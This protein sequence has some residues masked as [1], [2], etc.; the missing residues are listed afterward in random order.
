MSS[1]QL[2]DVSDI[3]PDGNVW[4]VYTST[5]SEKDL[6]FKFRGGTLQPIKHKEELLELI[7]TILL[8]S[9]VDK[10]T[11][12]AEGKFLRDLHKSAIV[13]T[14]LKGDF[15]VLP[16]VGESIQ[17]KNSD[18]NNPEVYLVI[19]IDSDYDTVVVK[20]TYQSF[21]EQVSYFGIPFSEY[22]K[23]MELIND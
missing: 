21:G 5:Y 2:K 18:L 19:A 14:K 1:I 12:K 3:F 23:G 22:F 16:K 13:Y 9:N 4:S 8:D 10:I 7:E 17:Y 6:A 15:R 20:H 11:V